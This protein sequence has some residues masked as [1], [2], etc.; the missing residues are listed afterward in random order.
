MTAGPFWFSGKKGGGTA[1]NQGDPP[2]YTLRGAPPRPTLVDT[3]RHSPWR[4]PIILAAV[5]IGW[6]LVNLS[7]AAFASPAGEQTAAPVEL[8]QGVTMTPASGWTSAA[9]VWDVGPNAVSLK[10]AGAVAVFAADAYDGSTEDLLAFQVDDLEA[11]FDSYSDL[12][13]A[14]S[15]VDGDLPALTVLFSG[16]ADSGRLEGELVAATDFGTGVVMLAIAPA[17]QLPRIQ[18]DLDAMLSSIVI[19]R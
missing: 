8:G 7:L 16:T 17:G 4:G 14:D 2:I 12:P 6:L 5:M 13:P 1:V 9:D 11:Q 3:P 18:A 19:P 15:T 10:R